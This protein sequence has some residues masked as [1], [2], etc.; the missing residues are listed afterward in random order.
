MSNDKSILTSTSTGA[1]LNQYESIDNNFTILSF[2][3]RNL[4]F[5]KKIF[6]RD[7]RVL[8][9]D[10]CFFK[11]LHHNFINKFDNLPFII[12]PK[13]NFYIGS[14]ATIVNNGGRLR[15]GCRW[16]VGT[17]KETEF[18][19]ANKGTLEIN[20]NFDI[21]TGSSII[22]DNGAKLSLGKGGMNMRTRIAAFDS[23]T[24]GDNV[25]ISENVTIRDSDNHPIKGGSEIVTAPI[26]IGNN[27]L[28]GINST[29]LK[30]VTIGDGAVV[31]ANSLVNKSVPPRT[32]VGGVP[33]KVI[34][35]NVTWEL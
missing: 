14:G 1:E 33:A 19:I 23:I 7:T 2:L 30:G 13:I 4:I 6:S 35:E 32:L 26:N 15:L 28:I 10:A 20:G 24:I 18:I 5:I 9:K 3:Y 17:F 25:Y 29:I 31:A 34:R 12:H 22:V 21:Y 27:V 11:T 16:G 8:L